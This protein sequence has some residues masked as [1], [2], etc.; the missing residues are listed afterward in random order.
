MARK[1][2]EKNVAGGEWTEARFWAF[3]RSNLR[4]MSR[5]WPPLARHALE[6]ARREYVGP[7]QR[8][9]WEFKC[10]CCGEWFMR[11]DVQVDHKV[12]CGS[13]ASY[14]DLVRFCMRLFCE[15]SGLRVLCTGCHD[16]RRQENIDPSKISA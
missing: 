9:K 5:K 10:A 1:V 3:F 2:V 11:K 12:P 14:D 15:E 13:L 16:V 6:S 7:N 8:Q 4:S